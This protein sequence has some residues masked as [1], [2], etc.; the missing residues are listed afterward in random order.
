MTRGPTLSHSQITAAGSEPPFTI[1]AN[2]RSPVA[3]EVSERPLGAITQKRRKSRKMGTSKPKTK[4]IEMEGGFGLLMLR[5][6]QS[7]HG[8]WQRAPRWAH[9]TIAA[10]HCSTLAYANPA[11]AA[12]LVCLKKRRLRWHLS[13]GSQRLVRFLRS[14]AKSPGK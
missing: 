7:N 8:S 3:N 2:Q 5:V 14:T 6:K 4:E 1:A 9:F 11:K 10:N 13:K 12:Q